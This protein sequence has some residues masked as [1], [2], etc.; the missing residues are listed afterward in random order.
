MLECSELGER[1]YAEGENEEGKSW[2]N[3]E[4]ARGKR[5]KQGK[6]K[7]R[8]AVGLADENLL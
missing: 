1:V 8:N 3:A 6:Q 5:K 7:S 2:G 4:E